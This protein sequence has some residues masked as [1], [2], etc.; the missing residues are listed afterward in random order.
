MSADLLVAKLVRD[1]VSVELPGE[2]AVADRAALLAQV[3]YFE[4]ASV[5]EACARARAYVGSWS[6]HPA[7]RHPARA[8]L[9]S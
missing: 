6:R 1:W 9:A 4:G 8:A 2:P 5:S 3:A 7:N